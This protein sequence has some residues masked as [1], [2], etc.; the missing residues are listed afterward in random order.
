[1]RCINTVDSA[2]GKFQED[3]DRHTHG[4]IEHP[5]SPL[6][7]S[8][9]NQAN[10]DLRIQ[11][12]SF[13]D[14]VQY[15]YRPEL[16]SYPSGNFGDHDK[17]VEKIVKAKCDDGDQCVVI[18]YARAVSVIFTEGGVFVLPDRIAGKAAFIQCLVDKGYERKITPDLEK[19]LIEVTAHFRCERDE[20]HEMTDYDL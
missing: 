5:K 8:D 20:I 19:E 6:D 18:R 7:D 3:M 13:A 17:S 16:S 15:F 2:M 1:M 12:D 11:A 4:E 10:A 14:L 9:Y